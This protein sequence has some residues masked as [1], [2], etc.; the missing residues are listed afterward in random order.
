MTW[1]HVIAGLLFIMAC[2]A[3]RDYER[4]QKEREHRER[5]E[6]ERRKR[7]EE[8]E[9]R[10]RKWKLNRELEYELCL[11][12]RE[13]EEKAKKEEDKKDVRWSAENRSISGS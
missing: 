6:E 4:R 10:W 8:E 1:G 2:D 9:E 13:A 12:K 11:L 5:A 3:R 7:M